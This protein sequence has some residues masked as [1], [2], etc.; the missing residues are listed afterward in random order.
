MTE[1]FSQAWR[2]MWTPPHRFEPN[3][4]EDTFLADY[5]Q[6]FASHRRVAITLGFLIGTAYLVWDYLYSLGDPDFAG[7]LDQ[8]AWNRVLSSVVI[9][10]AFVLSMGDRFNRDERFVTYLLAGTMIVEFALYCRGFMIAPYPYDYMYYFMGMF[11]CL[12]YGFSMLRLR[13]RPTI[14]M[15]TTMVLLA[16]VTFAWNWQTKEALLLTPVARIY[17]QVAL[18]FVVSVAIMGCT[19]ST[20]LERS[21]R[22]SFLRADELTRTNEALRVSGQETEERTQA[23]VELKDRMR[24]EAE[25]RNREKSQ[26]LAA[27][28]HDLKQPIQ[29]ICNAIDPGQRALARN[30]LDGTR[31]MLDLA[32]AATALMRE[33]LSAIL[34]ISRLESG[35]MQ[36]D[37]SSFDL[38]PVLGEAYSQLRDLADRYGVQLRMPADGAHAIVSSDRHSL[39]RIIR[40]LLENAIKYS[41]P[42]K[43]EPRWVE[44]RLLPHHDHVRVEIADNGLGIDAEHLRTEAIFKPFFQT[45]NLRRESEK[46]VGLGL[47]I[48]NSLLALMPDHDLKMHSRV[49]I[50]TT[51]ALD[52]P[53]GLVSTSPTVGY[54]DALTG[55]EPIT[56]AAALAGAYV[57]Y[58]EDDDFVRTAT[59]AL[60]DANGLL[61]EQADSLGKLHEVLAG[62]E[63]VPDVLLTDYRLPNEATAEHVVA[64]ATAAMG[65]MPVVVVTGE[66]IKPNQL[67]DDWQ[68][69]PKPVSSAQL[70]AAIFAAIKQSRIDV[71]G[72]A[73][74]AGD[75]E[76]SSRSDL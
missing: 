41:D 48:V 29:A 55:A 54:Q 53:Q 22:R 61:Y 18:S 11:I 50:G 15:M 68:F 70:L 34:E 75:A 25:R 3:V 28:V 14:V 36:A 4:L 10:P 32:D 12:I 24:E 7:F 60:F 43:P 51:A 62:L 45:H 6:R 57:L 23:L 44:L 65:P 67:A 47:S 30:D 33:Q 46:G 74:S 31:R 2:Q 27:A 8:V 13:S 63:R 71:A 37:I 40:N 9:L 20:L 58:V 35:F 56:E 5:C 26:F 52:I 64:A 72:V 73:P 19:V 38:G 16:A 21:E 42:R 66:P 17:T 69:L 59:C 39:S 1:T 49:G 76:P